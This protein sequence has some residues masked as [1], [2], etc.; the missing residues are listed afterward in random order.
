MPCGTC[1]VHLACKSHIQS[2]F[3]ARYKHSIVL[4]HV[5]VFVHAHRIQH[6]NP[7]VGLTPVTPNKHAHQHLA[8]LKCAHTHCGVTH[9]PNEGFPPFSRSPASIAMASCPIPLIPLVTSDS[10]FPW[11]NGHHSYIQRSYIQLYINTRTLS[12]N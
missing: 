4:I 8:T 7:S 9:N 12:W 6:F 2:E 11:R 10:D 5:H 1:K 3:G